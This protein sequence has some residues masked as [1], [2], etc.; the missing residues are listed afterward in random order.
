MPSFETP[1]P[2]SVTVQLGTGDLRFLAE[3]RTDTVVEVLPT[4]PERDG[5][6][7]LAGQTQVT[8]AG[9]RLHI[10]A[11]SSARCSAGRRP[12]TSSSNSRPVPRWSRT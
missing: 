3:D 11:P 1:E 12:W 10:K 6:V 4:D 7:R 2:I 8:Y 9:G 5:D